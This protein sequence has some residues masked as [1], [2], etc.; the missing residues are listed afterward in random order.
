MLLIHFDKEIAFRLRGVTAMCAT[1]QFFTLNCDHFG[2]S[3]GL[4]LG[5]PMDGPPECSP[6]ASRDV[7]MGAAV[8]ALH[9]HVENGVW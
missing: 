5:S 2:C 4:F 8:A 1:H 9:L 6:N 7:P 3:P